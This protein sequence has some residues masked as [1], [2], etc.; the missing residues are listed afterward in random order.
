MESIFEQLQFMLSKVNSL[1][2]IVTENYN[3]NPLKSRSTEQA[4]LRQKLQEE[5]LND[6]GTHSV[7]SLPDSGGGFS[8]LVF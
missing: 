1:I 6:C 7:L 5:A 2:H 4:T 3:R 8:H